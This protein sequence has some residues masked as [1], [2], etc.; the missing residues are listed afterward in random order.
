M[1][2]YFRFLL[3]MDKCLNMAYHDMFFY[4]LSCENMFLKSDVQFL[5]DSKERSLHEGLINVQMYMNK[6]PFQIEDFQIITAF[7]MDY[8]AENKRWKDT[9]LY[10]LIWL[11]HE[12]H[13]ERI[14]IGSDE[15]LETTASHVLS[16]IVLYEADFRIKTPNPKPYTGKEG[17]LKT[18][19]RQMLQEEFGITEEQLVEKDLTDILTKGISEQKKT[20]DPALVGLVEEFLA[21]EGKDKSLAIFETFIQGILQDYQIEEELIDR[22]NR[23]NEILA[24]LRLVEFLSPSDDIWEKQEDQSIKLHDYC[25][26]LWDRIW[27]DSSSDIER[28]YANMLSHYEKKLETC[29]ERSPHKASFIYNTEQHIPDIDKTLQFK[30]GEPARRIKSHET[31]YRNFQISSSERKLQAKQSDM[32]GIL[33][34]YRSKISK[35]S[36]EELLQSWEVAYQRI[37]YAIDHLEQSLKI[38][39]VTLSSEYIKALEK[40]KADK[41]L[42]NLQNIEDEEEISK[43][44]IRARELCHRCWDTLKQPQMLP[45]IQFQDELNLKSEVEQCNSD[46][47]FYMQCL[48]TIRYMPFMMLVIILLAILGLHYGALQPYVFTGT[49]NMVVYITYIGIS[50]VLMTLAWKIPDVYFRRCMKRL[51][52]RLSEEMSK[53]MK[54]YY[55]RG[56]NFYIYINTMNDLDILTAYME[57]LQ[58]IRNVGDEWQAK[59]LWHQAQ[60][61][62]HLQK[63]RANSFDGLIRNA[64]H[65]SE[66]TNN[67]ISIV[68]DSEVWNTDCEHSKIYWPQV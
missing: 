42:E 51:I 12:L 66:V 48:K 20:I 16:V 67:T 27:H 59:I 31:E 7:R 32:D 21:D 33:Q 8:H 14:Y 22:N 50:F 4:K 38:Y 68:E 5:M 63:V 29:L 19:I 54:G 3:N 2:K 36:G 56:Y 6:F 1:R 61:K 52:D 24:T 43:I 47:R 18:H 11:Y 30:D 10:R 39:G 49:T 9:L 62:K 44:E 57:M 28:R 45:S 41:F 64:D 23:K 35:G 26:S 55:D 40:R 34:E 53:Y 25:N 15:R 13:K 17:A 46:I 58:R 60:I 65:S 37:S